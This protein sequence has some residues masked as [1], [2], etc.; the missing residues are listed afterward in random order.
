M[1]EA[2]LRLEAQLAE[3]DAEE[4]EEQGDKMT[5]RGAGAAHGSVGVPAASGAWGQSKVDEDD[6]ALLAELDENER[7]ELEAELAGLRLE[8]EDDEEGSA[9][10]GTLS[11]TTAAAAP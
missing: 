10:T 6:E 3:L 5:P 7:A 9:T 4:K 2:E 11:E 1:L 8:E